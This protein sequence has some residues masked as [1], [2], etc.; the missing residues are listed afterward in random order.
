M[1]RTVEIGL[2]PADPEL[3]LDEAAGEWRY[4][5]PDWHELRTVVT[6]H[7]PMSQE[8]LDFRRLNHDQTA[9][10]RSTVLGANAASAVSAA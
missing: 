2:P 7:G 8:R 9:W 1:P 5:E 4:T 6:G 3:R 10:V